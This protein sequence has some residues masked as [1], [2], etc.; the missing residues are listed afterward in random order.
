MTSHELEAYRQRLGL[1]TWKMAAA[2]GADP[3]RYRRWVTG[4]LP[5]GIYVNILL[6]LIVKIAETPEH[7]ALREDAFI[8]TTWTAEREP[9]V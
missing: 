7:A 1:S 5:V 6:P 2:L 4:E 9:S 8:G 3:R